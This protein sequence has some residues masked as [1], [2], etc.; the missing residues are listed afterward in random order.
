MIKVLSNIITIFENAY[1]MFYLIHIIQFAVKMLL[2][3]V[4]IKAENDEEEK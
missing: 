1:H 3:H 4:I 2:K